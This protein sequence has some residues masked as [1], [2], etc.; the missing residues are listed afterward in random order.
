M[1]SIRSLSI[2]KAKCPKLKMHAHFLLWLSFRGTDWR[3]LPGSLHTS[4]WPRPRCKNR[5]KKG[6]GCRGKSFIRVPSVI[7]LI[8][9]LA[10]SL[11]DKFDH[12]TPRRSNIFNGSARSS[13][14][15][16]RATNPRRHR[17]RLGSG[18][19]PLPCHLAWRT[20]WKA[21]ERKCVMDEISTPRVCCLSFSSS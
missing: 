21:V 3:R 8:G 2:S 13:N 10:R 20:D 7:P 19:P 6:A 12:F 17:A 15:V 9:R 14:P 1:G 4:S 11:F 16:H 18:G 5:S